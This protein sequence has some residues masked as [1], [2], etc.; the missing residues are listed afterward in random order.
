MKKAL[1]LVLALVAGVTLQAQE[2]RF[3][4]GPNGFSM[5]GKSGSTLSVRHNVGAIT[6]EE[7]D[8]E[9]VE[10]QFI[11]WSGIFTDNEA[12]APNLPSSSAFVAIPNGAK[13]TVQLI[14]AKTKVLENVDLIP[15]PQPQLDNDDSQAIYQKD[16]SIYGRNALYPATPYTISE[17]MTVRGVEMVQVGVMP[18]QYNPVT[19]TLIVYEDM[20]LQLTCEGGDGIYGDIRYRTPEWDQILS[21]MLLNRDMLPDVD[22]GAKLRKHYENRE[23]GCEY[24]IITPDN[25]DFVQLADSIRLFRIQQGIPTEIFTVSQCGGNDEQSIKNFIR[26]AYNTWDMPP[27]AVLILGDHN[28]DPTK[29]VVSFI[30]NNHP[31]GDSYNPYISDHAYSV[32]GNNHMPDIIMGRITGRDYDELYHMIK[33][34]LDYERTPPTNPDFYDKPVTAM[35]FQLERWFQLC[36][37]V[38]NGFWEYE[39]GKH[40]VRIN[41]IYQGTPGS[42]WS[43]AENTNT[44]VNY[45][46]PNGCG[47][48][49]SNMSHLTDWSGNGNK[50]NDA[51]NNGAFLLQHRDHGAEELWGEPRYSINNIHRLTNNDLTYVMSNNCL[52]GR[53]NYGGPDGCFAEAFHRHQHGALGLIAATQVSYSFVNDVYVWG[54]Y[55]NLWPDFMPTYGTQHATNFLLPAFG[56]AAGKFFLRQS[57]WADS[58]VKEITYYLFHQHGDAYMNLYSEM[59]QNLDVEMLPVLVAG[60]GTYSIK[61]DEGAI[62]CLTVGDQ[63]IGFDQATGALQEI[64]ITP[65]IPGTRVKLTIK[66]QNF[67]RYEHELATIPAEGPYLIFNAVQINDEDGNQNLE[68]DYNETFKISVSVHNVGSS[69]MDNVNATLSCPNPKVQIIQGETHYG[70]IDAESIL[71]VDDAFTIHLDEAF[72]DGENIRL[73]LQMENQEVSFNDSITIRVNAPLLQYGDITF[74]NLDGSPTDRLFQ[75]ESSMVTFDIVNSGHSKSQDMTNTLRIIAPFLDITENPVHATAIEAGET[76]QV[77]F[78]VNLH[79]DAPQSNFLDYSIE[80]E[81]GF[82][83]IQQARQLP[84]GYITEDFENETLNP[85]IQWNLGSG[86]KVWYVAEDETATGGHCLHSPALSDQQ[87]SSLYIGFTCDTISTFSFLHKISTEVGDGL[88]L[89]INSTEIASWSGERDWERSEFEL[90]EG[91]NLIKLTFSK[92]S[93]GSGGDDCVLIDEMHFPPKED[94]IM[95]AGDDTESCPRDSFTPNSY[96]LRQKDILWTTDGDGVFDDPTLEQPTYSFG[97]ND[98]ANKTVNLTMTATSMLTEVPQSGQV[99]LHLFDDLTTV[100][101]DKPEGDTAVDLRLLATSEY[102]TSLDAA[103][104]QWSMEPEEAGVLAVDGN[105]ATITWNEAFRGIVSLRVK[106]SNDCGESNDSE[107]LN[108]HVVN[109]TGVDESQISAIKVYPNPANEQVYLVGNAMSSGQIVIRIIDVLGNVVYNARK[110]VSDHQFEVQINIS[111]FGSGLYDIQ[112]VS[113]NQTSNTR[114]IIQR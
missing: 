110:S 38:V 29:G 113:D 103:E 1:F 17:V 107:A 64:A 114:L 102:T 58:G 84:L 63:I 86:L 57:S 100:I 43:T 28:T 109:S 23:T 4:S 88:S 27:A 8:R 21:D 46:G 56:N 74:T 24:M 62:I 2:Y 69:A 22:Y 44:V 42:R 67:Y 91:K 45:F 9:G 80:T 90:R 19:K 40:P 95:F 104:C 93:Q 96:A 51:I 15:A 111:S 105:T 16:M 6:I 85:S 97:T 108:I 18:F 35:G 49:P 101:P 41:A 92:N 3:N 82:H 94:L 61:A 70:T 89:Y 50:V 68:A 99:T 13:P 53:F 87:N 98:I 112:I 12:G 76:T 34:D 65:Q 73:Y 5:N 75:G 48:I 30:M 7:T 79:D 47:Y 25:E 71:T 31:G 39:L 54:M 20:E 72:E 81:N 78:Q 36:S 10:G 59:P 14:S 60:S 106:Q 55:D 37:E 26:N 83:T 11:S 33:K 66:K 52:T 77:S 32:M